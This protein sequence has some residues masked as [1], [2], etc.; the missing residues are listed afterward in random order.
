MTPLYLAC[1][2]GHV[3]VARDLVAHGADVNT[4][5]RRGWTPLIGASDGGHVETVEFLVREAKAD[6]EGR[7]NI[8]GCT[9]LAVAAWKGH[10]HV[11]EIL[12]AAGAEMNAR[13][14]DGLTPLQWACMEG[15][16]EGAKL[17]IDHGAD[18]TLADDY[19]V[20]AV[21]HALDRRDTSL[22]LYFM[23]LCGIEYVLQ[24]SQVKPTFPERLK[25]EF[26]EIE[27][28]GEGAFGKV[29]KAEKDGEDYA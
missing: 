16:L 3:S 4:K 11:M 27:K 8:T 25:S 14:S 17:L 28:L 21:W 13:D 18:W 19:G 2:M 10:T 12:L 6:V 23:S 9:A 24:F 26:T 5:D 7:E 22:L 29:V 20:N 1:V 15:S